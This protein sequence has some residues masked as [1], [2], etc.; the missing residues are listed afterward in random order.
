MAGEWAGSSAGGEQP[1]FLA[2]LQAPGGAVR[3][4]LVKFSPPLDTETGRPWADLLVCEAQALA[5]LAEHGVAGAGTQLLEAGGRRFLEVDRHDRVGRH[6]RRGVVSLEAVQAALVPGAANDWPAAAAALERAG[7]IDAEARGRI[8]RLHSFGEMIGNTDMH[9]GNLSF[10][11][12]DTVPFR[13]TPAYD[14]LPMAWAPSRFGELVEP[15]NMSFAPRP[16]LPGEMTTWREAAGWAA[17]F[18]RRVGADQR[19]SPEFV[20]RARVAGDHVT[21]MREHFAP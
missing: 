1:K 12:D 19:V 3:H 15:A 14:M 16:P 10:W 9:F 11:L 6:G 18:W 8:Q 5:L 2:E 13:P 21:R 17:E 4:V 7:L 20:G